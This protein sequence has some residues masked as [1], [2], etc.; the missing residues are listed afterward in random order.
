M[1]R[2]RIFGMDVA[3]DVMLPAPPSTGG[4]RATVRVVLGKNQEAGELL[5]TDA[6]PQGCSCWKSENSVVVGW[7]EASFQVQP[8]QVVV[9]ALD[10]EAAVGLLIPA[11]WS[12]VLAA[13]GH[14]SLHGCTVERNGSAVAILGSSGTGK[15][16]AARMLLEVGGRLV[17]DDLL[18]FDD[19]LRAIPG[20]PTLR[21]EPSSNSQHVGAPDRSGKHRVAVAGCPRPVPVRGIVVLSD[22]YGRWQQLKGA[23]AVGALLEQ[24]YVPFTAWPDQAKARLALASTLAE[25]AAIYAAPPRSLT[26]SQ[27]AA[28]MDEVTT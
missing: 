6:G 14:E 3:S 23:S 7:P 25:R 12:L 15:S 8:Q 27:L 13:N 17:T 24:V 4:G 11:V 28:F 2:Y 21:L 18:A 1:G 26:K 9:D 19:R 22:S 20:P 10:V 16:T 5:W